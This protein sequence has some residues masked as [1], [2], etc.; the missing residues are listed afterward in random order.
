VGE[1][2]S[3]LLLTATNAGLATMPLSLDPDGETLALDDV[4]PGH[5]QI[6]VRTGWPVPITL[7]ARRGR[8]APRSGSP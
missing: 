3:S 4:T 2:L 1:A 8:R 6:V 5:P 7:P